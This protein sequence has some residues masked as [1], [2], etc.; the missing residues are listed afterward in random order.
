LG[1]MGL[2]VCSLEKIN[3]EKMKTTEIYLSL[4]KSAIWSTPIEERILSGDM[5]IDWSELFALCQRQGTGPL[6]FNELLKAIDRLQATGDRLQAMVMQMKQYCMQNMLLQSQWEQIIA[7]TWD[8]LS[9]FHP[10]MLKG[11]SLAQLY[12]LP[13]LRQWGDLDVWCGIQNYHPACKALREAFPEAEHSEEE[14]DVLKH[15][16]VVLPNGCAIELHRVSM[17]FT[18]PKEFERYQQL[19]LEAMTHSEIGPKV[20]NIQVDVPESKFNLLFTFLHAWEH[21]CGTGMPM[22]QVCDM[23]LLAHYTY[24]TKTPAEK[25][26]M[27]AYLKEQLQFFGML[28]VWQTIGAM[29]VK[30]FDLPSNEWPLYTDDIE[31]SKRADRL[32]ATILEEGQCRKK[33]YIDGEEDRKAA[34]EKASNMPLLLR[35]WKTLQSRFGESRMLKPYAPEYARHLLLNQIRHGI[36]R[37]IRREEIFPI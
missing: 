19:E 20:G 32:M 21:F 1:K 13:Y 15:Y 29:I 10:V 35:K 12:P 16:C 2:L 33:V 11:F 28:E 3:M 26:N 17:D 37:T 36:R 30:T 22:K 18:E 34:W 14:W 8:A 7:R 25:T 24:G 31:F 27:D 5:K 9:N 23:A 4:L 6:I